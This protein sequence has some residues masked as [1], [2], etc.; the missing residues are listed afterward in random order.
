MN[1]GGARL[2]VTLLSP[3]GVSGA[4]NQRPTYARLIDWEPS[5]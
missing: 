2:T 4:R 3:P 1:K 5:S